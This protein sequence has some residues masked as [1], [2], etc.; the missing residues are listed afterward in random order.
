MAARLA[1]T[2]YV[3][4]PDTHQTV[5]LHQGTSPEPRLAALVKSPSAWVDGKLP[6]L[7]KTQTDQKP[8]SPEDAGPTGDGQDDAS[9]A[10]SVA[11]DDQAAPTAKKTAARRTAAS[12]PARGRGAAD[13]G[14]SGD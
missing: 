13:E 14:S 4:D 9:G 12:K 11:G 10:T 3:T 5:T 7:P 1:A 6:R 2:V 8:D